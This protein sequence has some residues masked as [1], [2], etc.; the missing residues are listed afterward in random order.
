MQGPGF[1]PQDPKN[2]TKHKV[3]G[4][5]MPKGNVYEREREI[6]N[7]NVYVILKFMYWNLNPK[8]TC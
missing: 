2:K 8:V 1:H 6:H 7:L 4:K 3:T 5:L